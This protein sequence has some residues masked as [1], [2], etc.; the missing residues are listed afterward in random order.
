ML[1]KLLAFSLLCVM[2][3]TFTGCDG[4][5]AAPN[6]VLNA[7]KLTGELEGLESAIENTIKDKYD[8]A[9]PSSGE[10]RT[11]CIQIDLDGNE[12]NEVLVF[13][14]PK[15]DGLLH[16]NL[17]VKNGVDWKSVGDVSLESASVEKV[18]FKNL[19]GDGKLEI[20]IG[21]VGFSVADLRTKKAFVYS[22]DGEKIQPK[23]QENCTDFALCN[24]LDDG[25]NQLMMVNVSLT[26]PSADNA[27]T[28]TKP[29]LRVA[30]A[31]LIS[32]ADNSQNVR[33]CGEAQM[34][35][36][37]LSI[38]SSIQGKVDGKPALFVDSNVG[39]NKISTS[40]FVFD[41]EKSKLTNPLYDVM[42]NK[43]TLATRPIGLLCQDIDGDGNI[44]IPFSHN[45]D[46]DAQD[47][48]VSWGRYQN[49]EMTVGSSG[50]YNTVYSYY[51]DIPTKWTDVTVVSENDGKTKIYSV[52]PS[53]QM[54][55]G[56]KL[57]TIEIKDKKSQTD[58]GKTAVYSTE[59]YNFY[60]ETASMPTEYSIGTE[61]I[62]SSFR[63]L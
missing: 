1:K 49:G 16:F 18:F 46:S 47:V 22:Y 39:T 13:Y 42:T 15:T 17:F 58:N 26:Q 40:V 3:V 34:E 32:V 30:T 36:G 45:Q 25:Y 2:M 63:V 10:Y 33:Y 21:T 51:F 9:Y 11:S 56:A 38:A 61:I 50:F 41:K 55:G 62:K 4:L 48:M 8:F 23:F 43:T 7:P 31:R 59:N 12:I 35:S 57:C 37:I 28:E 24:L 44:E 27:A 14:I 53:A 29:V 6:E 5:F 54:N 60:L 19:C 20:V 52:S